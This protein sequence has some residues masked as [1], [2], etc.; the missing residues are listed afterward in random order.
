MLA[1]SLQPNRTE[2][3]QL[4][5]DLKNVA[6]RF[7]TN[8]GQQEK[9]LAT[10]HETLDPNASG[11]KADQA[12]R[13]EQKPIAPQKATAEQPKAPGRPEASVGQSDKGSTAHKS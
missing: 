2:P 8:A 1:A 5:A 11:P 3:A 7:E 12:I 9:A 4:A 10:L 6:E 13:T